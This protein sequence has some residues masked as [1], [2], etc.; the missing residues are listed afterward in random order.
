MLNKLRSNKGFTLIELLIVVAIIGILAA[1]AIPQ[2][3]KYRIQGYN[4]TAASDMKN[5]RTSEES[6]F[7]EWQG[8]GL[9]AM[10]AAV[11]P[12]VWNTGGSG[13]GNPVTAPVTAGGAT[14]VPTLQL[15]DRSSVARGLQIAVGNNVTL[16]A[17][18]EVV[19][20][21]QVPISFRIA[22]K[23][24]QGDTT[25]AADSDSTTNYK[26]STFVVGVNEPGVVVPAPP[27]SVPNVIDPVLLAAPYVAM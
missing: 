18:T 14:N 9:S 15:D 20:A 10:E 13:P 2:F 22:S 3:A 27:V 8:Y 4:S 26:N 1:I 21:G 17:N 16:Y 25:F 24:L 7:A 12:M 11:D 23:H 5:C 6:L 19:A